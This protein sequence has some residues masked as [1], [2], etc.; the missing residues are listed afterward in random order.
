MINGVSGRLQL[1]QEFGIAH[2]FAQRWSHGRCVLE[3]G[4]KNPPICR[5]YWV[6]WVKHVQ[7]GGS[8]VGVD[9]DL[10]AVPHI[11]NRGTAESVMRRIGVAVRRRERVDNPEKPPA[12]TNDDVGVRIVSQE[13]RAAFLDYRRVHDV[14]QLPLFD[15][16]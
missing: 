10:N 14:G 1:K 16:L 12:V 5:D 9:D 6:L 4:R 13:W 2:V 7:G 15:A 11:I 8:I 3:Q